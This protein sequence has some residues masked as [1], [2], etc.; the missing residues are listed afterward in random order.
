MPLFIFCGLTFL[1]YILISNKV[2]RQLCWYIDWVN[3]LFT[4]IYAVFY[5]CHHPLGF[6]KAERY[7]VGC[8]S[9]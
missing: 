6:L 8:V 7:A 1:V 3:I 9:R 2:H 5:N 4:F